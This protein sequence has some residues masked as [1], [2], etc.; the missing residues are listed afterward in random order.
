[1][2][3][4]VLGLKIT[5]V[6]QLMKLK[7]IILYLFLLT[8]LFRTFYAQLHYTFYL[9]DK[10]TY[11]ELFCENKEKPDLH[12]DG[13]CSLNK[14]SGEASETNHDI[15]ERITMLSFPDFISNDEFEI[16]TLTQCDRIDN[17]YANTFSFYNFLYLDNQKEPPEF[18]MI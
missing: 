8:M 17:Q 14:S 12:C 2:S 11:V 18:S 7:R 4:F 16:E 5:F 13:K 15:P 6:P 10:E 3:V 1:M 9:L